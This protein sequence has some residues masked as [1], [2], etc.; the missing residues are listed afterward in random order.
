MK[1]ADKN[2]FLEL[3]IYIAVMVVG[4]VASAYRNYVKRKEQQ[5]QPG[6][7]KP[8]PPESEY[9]PF[10]EEEEPVFRQ[11]VKE[12]SEETEPELVTGQQEEQVREREAAE[13]PDVVSEEGQKVF[14]YAANRIVANESF[15]SAEEYEP[16]EIAD[17]TQEESTAA[18]TDEEAG[19][20]LKEAVIYSEILNAKYL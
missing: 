6:N 9:D 4:L 1:F 19:F 2:G 18:N 3:F 12:V 8:D 20:S 5:N 17:L 7:V 14:D 11:P 13:V 15:D 10:F 16:D